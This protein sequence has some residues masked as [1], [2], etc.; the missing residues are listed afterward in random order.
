MNARVT[1]AVTRLPKLLMGRVEPISTP[2]L[3]PTVIPTTGKS[4]VLLF[5]QITKTHGDK[6]VRCRE[7]LGGQTIV[8]LREGGSHIS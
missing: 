1:K 6:R 7:R 5:P 3:V 4:N 2:T 8:D